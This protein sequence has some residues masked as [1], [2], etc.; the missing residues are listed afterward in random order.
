[1]H[2]QERRND[3][4]ALRTESN[5]RVDQLK[6]DLKFAF[7]DFRAKNGIK[8]SVVDFANDPSF[9]QKLNEAKKLGLSV[10]E[11][12]VA[13]D[14]IRDTYGKKYVVHQDHVKISPLDRKYDVNNDTETKYDTRR[15]NSK[16]TEDGSSN[17]ERNEDEIFLNDMRAN[18]DRIATEAD[19]RNEAEK[20]RIKNEEVEAGRAWMETQKQQAETRER[21]TSQREA[22][23]LSGIEKKKQVESFVKNV[24]KEFLSLSGKF[25]V[26]MREDQYDKAGLPLNLE[27]YS[28]Y[29]NGV[30]NDIRT[31]MPSE[32][33]LQFSVRGD[34]LVCTA[35]RSIE[36]FNLASFDLKDLDDSSR[37][38]MLFGIKNKW[39]TF[40][41]SSRR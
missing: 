11:M 8:A 15:E 41:S 20:K 16:R 19:A 27:R 9:V 23:I 22:D 12:G 40:V 33:D 1:M 14:F 38:Q 32:S 36:G 24:G 37:T 21:E 4:P 29:M 17:S 2:S 5:P 7:W 34:N 30:Y 39:K 13:V 31:F 26:K 10:E 6:K 18:L 28:S 25:F 3:N 35:G